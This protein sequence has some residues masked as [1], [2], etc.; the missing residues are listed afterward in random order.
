MWTLNLWW[1]L[2]FN[3]PSYSIQSTLHNLSMINKAWTLLLSKSWP[4]KEEKAST[5]TS[6]LHS[7]AN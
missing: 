4:S 7:I 6:N 5:Y 1:W 3:L 2:F